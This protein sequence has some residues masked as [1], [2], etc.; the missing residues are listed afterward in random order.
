[1]LS[2]RRNLILFCWSSQLLFLMHIIF[3]ILIHSINFED[4]DVMTNVSTF[5]KKSITM[6]LYFLTIRKV[7]NEMIKK[8]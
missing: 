4:C 3:H 8:I 5:D 2:L 1:M 7:W 6:S